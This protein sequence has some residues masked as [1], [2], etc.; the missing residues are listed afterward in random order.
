MLLYMKSHLVD[1]ILM[2]TRTV[3]RILRRPAHLRLPCRSFATTSWRSHGQDSTDGNGP[4]ESFRTRLGAAL[5]KTKIEWY[6]IPVGLGIAFLGLT[7]MFKLQQWRR[8][9]EQERDQAQGHSQQADASTDNQTASSTSWNRGGVRPSNPWHIQLMFALPLKAI[10]RLWGRFNSL[11]IP[12]PLR[13]PGFRLYAWLFGVNLDEVGEDDLRAY[14]NLA[15]FFYRALKPGARPLDPDI[16]A[17]LAPSDGRVLHFGVI[18]GGEVEQVKGVTYSLDA[19][20]GREPYGP[21]QE[22]GLGKKSEAVQPSNRPLHHRHIDASKEGEVVMADQEFAEMNGLNYTL[23]ELLGGDAAF[24]RELVS[25]ASTSAS[26]SGNS[27]PDASLVATGDSEEAVRAELS[28]RR[29]SSWFRS[30]SP[31]DKDLYFAVVYLAPGDYHR[32]H[33]PVP[34]VVERRRHFAGELFSVSPY[35]QRKLPGLFTL[36]ERAAL[37]GRWRWGFFSLTP[38]GATNVGS[39]RINFDAQLRTNSLAAEEDAAK[40]EAQS[41]ARGGGQNDGSRFPYHSY[42][43]ATYHRASATLRGHALQRG[44]EMGGFQLGSTIVLVFEAPAENQ[45]DKDGGKKGFEWKI[46]RGQRVKMGQALGV[47]RS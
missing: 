31:M 27:L 29:S 30:P 12:R 36:N 10:S 38:V 25:D 47:A 32:F 22:Q 24:D 9:Q 4:K 13:V 14:P 39:I 45:G 46:E 6:P 11:D 43:E 20:L 3:P 26:T 42:A 19:L 7:Q 15:S 16:A 34:W 35:L 33:S 44:E 40:A 5:G 8:E 28:R 17:V 1:L 21:G 23:P 2:D 18:E 41:A 37:L